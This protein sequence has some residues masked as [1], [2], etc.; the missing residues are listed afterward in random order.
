MPYRTT[1]AHPAFRFCLKHEESLLSSPSVVEHILIDLILFFYLA[2]KGLT[3]F[4]GLRSYFALD[5]AIT[6]EE[7]D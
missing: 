7:R 6:D 1:W 5:F 2:D 4:S 3:L